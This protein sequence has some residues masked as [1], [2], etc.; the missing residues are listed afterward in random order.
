MPA[1]TV[2]S[3]LGFTLLVAGLMA[4]R[5]PVATCAQCPHCQ[6]EQL[7]KERENED[8]VGRYYGFPHCGACGGYHT[9]EQPHRR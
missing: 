9:R 1:V 3:I 5:L 7:A 2:I 6:V 8:R 4:W